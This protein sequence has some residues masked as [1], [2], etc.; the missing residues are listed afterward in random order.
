MTGVR[1]RVEESIHVD[2]PPSVVYGYCLDP[3][4]LFAGD[5]KH[6]VDAEVTDS[7]VGTTAHLTMSFGVLKEE[8][9]L[10]YVEVVPDRRIEIAMQ[11]TMSPRVLR[12][13]HAET[14]LYSL[15]HE[16][17]PE[18]DGTRMTLTVRVHDAPLHERMIDRLE[19]KGPNRMV[20]R[21]LQRIADAVGHTAAD[22]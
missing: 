22:A 6:V 19:G 20:Q 9:E 7:G 12:V 4:R 18:D 14:A 11:P 13:P 21:R 16:F 15:I 3:R 17:E 10:E 8:D 2:A 5:P 1:T